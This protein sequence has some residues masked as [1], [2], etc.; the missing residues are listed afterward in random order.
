MEYV[1]LLRMQFGEYQMTTADTSNVSKMGVLRV[2]IQE[3]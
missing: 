1:D 2:G 3:Q